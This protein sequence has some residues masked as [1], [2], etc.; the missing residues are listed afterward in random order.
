MRP[1]RRPL[2]AA[3]ATISFYRPYAV[4]EFNGRC[5]FLTIN[6]PDGSQKPEV[7][8]DFAG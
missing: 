4:E 5:G 1:R 3:D 2:T 7:D 8:V 6:C